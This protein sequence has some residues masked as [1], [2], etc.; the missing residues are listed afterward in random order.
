MEEHMSYTNGIGSLQ[1]A[2][3]SIAT[4]AAKPSAAADVPA[5][6]AK[7]EA[8]ILSAERADQTELSAASGIMAQALEGSDT[9]SAKVA[10]LQQAI[11]SGNYNVSSSDVADKMI[12]SLLG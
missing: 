3:S 6:E 2:L 1:Q 4:V 7:S 12:Q 11:A 8:S 9:R 5:G 10:A